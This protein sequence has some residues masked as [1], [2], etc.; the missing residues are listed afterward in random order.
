MAHTKAQGAAK[1]TVN[2]AGKRLGVKKYAGEN[3]ISGNIIIR[4]RGSKFHPGKNTAMGK[5][6]TIF[7]TADGVVRFRDMTGNHSGQKFVDVVSE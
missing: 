2:I 6:F 4:Q 7:A 1:R 3:V 5:D